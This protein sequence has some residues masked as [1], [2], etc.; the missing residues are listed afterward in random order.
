M[1]AF[2]FA[3]YQPVGTCVK[4]FLSPEFDAILHR[5]KAPYPPSKLQGLA[6]LN[7]KQRAFSFLLSKPQSR[8]T[9]LCLSVILLT[10]GSPNRNASA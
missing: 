10:R 2:I 7:Y 8:S 5:V 9:K 3:S 6:L 1:T 4:E